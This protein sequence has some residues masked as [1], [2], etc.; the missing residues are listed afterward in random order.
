MRLSQVESLTLE[1]IRD[2]GDPEASVEQ[3]ISPER[4]AAEL[5]QYFQVRVEWWG[6]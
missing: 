5:D 3:L 6:G 2:E 1:K 4:Y